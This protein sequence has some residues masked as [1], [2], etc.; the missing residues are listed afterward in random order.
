MKSKDSPRHD[1]KRSTPKSGVRKAVRAPG[2]GSAI[3]LDFVLKRISLYNDRCG[4]G[5]NV[6]KD[7]HGYTLYLEQ[8]KTPIARL[9][10]QVGTDDYEIYHWS[11][12]S[13]RW[14]RVGQPGDL[15]LPLDEALDFI[16]N[17]PMDCFWY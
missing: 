16:A 12:F 11:P 4:G 17:D 7:P 10:P 13:Q 1:P 3:V 5:V 6:R 2:G 14:Q 9:K 15:I 8:E